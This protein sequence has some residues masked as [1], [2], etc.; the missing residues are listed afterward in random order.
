MDFHPITVIKEIMTTISGHH[1][2]SHM[3]GYYIS[4]SSDDESVFSNGLELSEDGKIHLCC[5][6]ALAVLNKDA[7]EAET[8]QKMS[9]WRIDVSGMPIDHETHAMGGPMNIPDQDIGEMVPDEERTYGYFVIT[10]PIPPERI[11]GL[12]SYC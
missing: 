4:P 12:V 1:T 2:P 11:M 9:I 5:K 3:V 8:D 10:S 7:R 6:L